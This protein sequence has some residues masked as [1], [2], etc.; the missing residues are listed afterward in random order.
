MK[1]PGTS[2]ILISKMLSLQRDGA[3]VVLA[4]Q[5]RG[6]NGTE[7]CSKGKE[8]YARN[9]FICVTPVVHGITEQRL[10]MTGIFMMSITI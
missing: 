1:L 8:K 3:C 7:I 5:N 6:P 4:K 9:R 10:Q 2:V